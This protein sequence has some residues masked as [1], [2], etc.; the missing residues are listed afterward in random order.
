[1]QAKTEPT[2]RKNSGLI[3]TRCILIRCALFLLALLR[4]RRKALFPKKLIDLKDIRFRKQIEYRHIHAESAI[5]YARYTLRQILHITAFP[6]IDRS[7][8]ALYN[9]S[10]KKRNLEIAL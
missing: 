5:R 4:P 3:L 2:D 7:A 10:R 1:M 6:D 8:D 9:H